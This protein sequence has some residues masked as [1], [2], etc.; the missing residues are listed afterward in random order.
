MPR[1]LRL[2]FL[3]TTPTHDTLAGL[4]QLSVRLNEVS[5]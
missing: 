2:R 3:L 1:I 4:A 5:I